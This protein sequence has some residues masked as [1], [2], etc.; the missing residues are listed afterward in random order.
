MEGMDMEFMPPLIIIM[1]MGITMGIITGIITDITMDTD[2]IMGIIMG[3]FIIMGIMASIAR[4]SK[5]M[6]SISEAI[7]AGVTHNDIIPDFQY[8]ETSTHHL[9]PVEFSSSPGTWLNTVEFLTHHWRTGSPWTLTDISSQG[10]GEV[11]TTTCHTHPHHQEAHAIHQWAQCLMEGMDM[12]F[13]PL[14][15]IIMATDI[16]TGIITDITM[17]TD[18]IMGIIMGIMGIM[19]SIARRSKEMASISEAIPAV[20][21]RG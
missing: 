21:H 11:L 12:E 15:I 2:T 1:A 14:L 13:P 6:A 20:T 19:A 4:R 18:T 7:P 10:L 17:D 16:I 8:K 5:E 3:F 9:A